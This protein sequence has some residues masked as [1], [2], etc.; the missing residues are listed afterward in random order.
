MPSQPGRRIATA[1]MAAAIAI[2]AER[3]ATSAAASAAMPRT[4]A[5]EGGGG[6]GG[7][8]GQDRRGSRRRNR[9]DR[10]PARPRRWPAGRWRWAGGAHGPPLPAVHRA[11]EFPRKVIPG[12]PADDA[13]RTKV[14]AN[15]ICGGYGFRRI[16]VDLAT[17]SGCVCRAGLV[18]PF[19]SVHAPVF[20]GLRG[21]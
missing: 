10:P 15:A 6:V 11:R 9:H 1:Q 17:S 2:D 18:S 21:G 4:G 3:R 12:P 14:V 20:L 5:A 19:W 7:P 16:G 8:F 13:K